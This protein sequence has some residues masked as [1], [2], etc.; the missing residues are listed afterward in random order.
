M[1]RAYVE[2]TEGTVVCNAGTTGG[3]G[4]RYLD[5]AEGVALSAAILTFTRPPPAAPSSSSTRSPSTAR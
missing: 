1:H 2:T 5:R 4:L 3:A